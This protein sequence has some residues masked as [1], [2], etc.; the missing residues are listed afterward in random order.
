SNQN[1]VIPQIV[2]PSI[3]FFLSYFKR[4][5]SKC[6]FK[7]KAKNRFECSSFEE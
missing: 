2:W 5:S 6:I 7:E 4:L 1:S 3:S